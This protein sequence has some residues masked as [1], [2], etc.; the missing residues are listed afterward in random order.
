MRKR[1]RRRTRQHSKSI[2]CYHQ[3]TRRIMQTMQLKKYDSNTECCVVNFK[4][5]LPF[6][7][8][9]LCPLYAR[10]PLTQCFK[11]LIVILYDASGRQCD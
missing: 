10:M 1:L 9:F 7:V 11:G 3:E 2:C 4:A 8:K 6:V 5:A